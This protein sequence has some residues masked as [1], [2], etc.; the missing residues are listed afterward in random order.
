MF[1]SGQ[2]SPAVIFETF[3]HQAGFSWSAV[4]PKVAQTG[5]ACWYDRAGYG[6]S[7]DGPLPRT[8]KAV[9]NDLHALLT[10]AKISPPYVLVGAY[11]AV[12]SIRVFNGLYPHDVAGALFIE[13][14]N[15]DIYAHRVP[16]PDSIKGPWE[17]SFGSLAP[18]GRRSFCTVFP[19]IR[20]L[21]WLLPKIGK[22]RPT[23]AYGIPTDQD[24]MLDFLSDRGFGEM[25]DV[26]QNETDVLAAGDFGDRPL[27]VLASRRQKA[28]EQDRR[29]IVQEW[30]DSRATQAQSRLASLSTVGKLSVIDDRVG[31]DSIVAAVGE[32]VEKVKH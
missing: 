29:T 14:N 25:C 28:P 23:L 5:L 16:V 20:L 32:L 27:I 15:I 7:D 11:D 24:A 9:A 19:L 6:W 8:F 17:K 22:P 2:G 30:N 12:S 13:G 4:Q 26:G 3:S 10:A 1:C 18:Y 21:N 31:L